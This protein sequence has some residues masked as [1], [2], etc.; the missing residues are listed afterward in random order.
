MRGHL[1]LNP[2]GFERIPHRIGFTV[3][4]GGTDF[5][6]GRGGYPDP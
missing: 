3:I 2:V 1:F 4:V 5:I 6:G